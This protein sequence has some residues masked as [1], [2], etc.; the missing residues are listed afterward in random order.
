V[1]GEYRIPFIA[2][3]AIVDERGDNVP[4]ELHTS[5]DAWGRP[6]V[7]RLLG[8][9]LRDPG[10]LTHLPGLAARMHKATHALRAAANAAG[11]ELGRQTLQPC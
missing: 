7:G 3:R 5:V 2:L 9:V 10:L 11:M 1:A 4:I 8:S 6:R